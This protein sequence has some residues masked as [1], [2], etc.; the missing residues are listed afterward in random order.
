MEIKKYTSTVNTSV[1]TVPIKYLAIH[2]TAGTTSKKGSAISTAKY[3]AKPKTGASAD[4]IV[5]DVDV[6][7]YN[8]DLKKRYCWAVGTKNGPRKTKAGGKWYRKAYNANTIS[9]EICSSLKPGFVYKSTPANS[10]GWYFTE[11]VLKNAE[12]LAKYLMKEY[13]IPESNVIR[14]YDVTGKFC[15]GVVGWNEDTGSIEEWNKFKNKLK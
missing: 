11:A 15:P 7:Q 2:Y 1:R 10:K 13:K 12:E 9:I 3:F 6:V 4:F 5:D 8:P 14:H